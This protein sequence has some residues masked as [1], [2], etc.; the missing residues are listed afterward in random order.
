MPHASA[1]LIGFSM[2]AVLLL[3]L[4]FATAY[5]RVDLPVQS[6]LGGYVMLAALLVTQWGHLRI[7]DSPAPMPLTRAYVIFLFLQAVGF[8]WFVLG[9]LR[10]AGQWRPWE[11]GLALAV[12]AVGVLVPLEW[13]IPLALLIGT[14]FALHLAA[15]LY[16][17]RAMRRRFRLE[18]SVVLLFALMGSV[19][20]AVGLA[21]PFALGWVEYARVYAALIAC[22][23]FLAVWLLLTVPDIV[24][25]TQDAVALSYAQSTLGRVNV[26]AKLAAL[27]QLFERDR[28]HRDETL[29]LA[30]ASELL[31]LSPH[32][33]SE[34]VNSRLETGFSKLVRQYRVQDAQHMLL[35]EPDASVLSI[36]MAVGFAS[37]STFYIAFKEVQGMT[38]AQFRKRPVELRTPR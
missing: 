24:A 23:L 19:A 22:G 10:P 1:L 34:L 7:I 12:L 2:G 4:A 8:Y 17:L 25:K 6:R 14:G 16:R 27:H 3:A 13:A 33:L 36:G 5:R 32:Q 29:S 31:D 28:I 30:R 35:D 11:W 38:P 18:V 26:D 21:A 37:Q 15:L 20:A 9:V